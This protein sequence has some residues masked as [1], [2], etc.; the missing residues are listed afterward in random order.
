MSALWGCKKLA[1]AAAA[2]ALAGCCEPSATAERCRSLMQNPDWDNQAA[3]WIRMPGAR[4]EE[5]AGGGPRAML[6][7][8]PTDAPIA[9]LIPRPARLV[10]LG[11]V[12]VAYARVET[13]HALPPTDED[14]TEHL[15][16][17]TVNLVNASTRDGRDFP[18]PYARLRFSGR[19]VASGLWKRLVTP[20]IPTRGARFLYPHFAFWG[21]RL[22]PGVK[23]RLAAMSLLEAETGG[24][25]DPESWA[26]CPGLPAPAAVVESPTGRQWAQA[27][28]PNGGF[29]EA[30]TME[31]AAAGGEVELRLTGRY[32]QGAMPADRLLIA[33]TEDGS[34][35]R[36]SPTSRVVTVLAQ[37]GT[38]EFGSRL[39]VKAP[40]RQVRL[41]VAAA[42]ATEDGLRAQTPL[43]PAAWQ[44]PPSPRL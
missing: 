34:D 23:L 9:Q 16:D 24:G 6:I 4:L 42:A 43:L 10:G 39:R 33:V 14:V 25:Q 44:S 37:R 30:F 28:E 7:E 11:V 21:T 17:G 36:L 13:A 41:A 18:G 20:V 19:E 1:V 32:R 22:R 31:R 12:A 35:P 8:G 38:E 27:L 5:P 2:L 15:W 26:A 29:E 3:G 40:A